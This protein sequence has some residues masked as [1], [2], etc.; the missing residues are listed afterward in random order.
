MAEPPQNSAWDDFRL[1][2]AIA[3]AGSLPAA[4]DLLGIN[5]STVF[6]RLRQIEDALGTPLFEKHRSRLYADPAAARRSPR[7]PSAST[8]TSTA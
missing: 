1:I 8:R 7:S 3:E 4:A 5:H 2:K 6:R